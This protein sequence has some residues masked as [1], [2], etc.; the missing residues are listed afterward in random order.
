MSTEWFG[1]Q[2]GDPGVYV[3]PTNDLDPQGEQMLIFTDKPDWVK[4][5]TGPYAGQQIAVVRAF[6]AKC[7]LCGAVCKVLELVDPE[8]QPPK[9]LHTS[10]CGACKQFALYRATY[11]P[12]QPAK[13]TEPQ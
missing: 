12:I 7:R 3:K 8:P 9:K 11:E 10:D 6:Q 5:P 13:P 2:P 4:F 1:R